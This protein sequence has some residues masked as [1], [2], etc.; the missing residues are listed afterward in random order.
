MISKVAAEVAEPTKY[1][2]TLSVVAQATPPLETDLEVERSVK[3]AV[4]VI[5]Y[6][7]YI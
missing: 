6:A 1:Q 2:S 5:A 3:L 4:K 7:I